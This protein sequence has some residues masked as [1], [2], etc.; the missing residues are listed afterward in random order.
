MEKKRTKRMVWVLAAFTLV[1]AL[2]IVTGCGD[3]VKNMEGKWYMVSVSGTSYSIEINPDGEFISMSGVGSWEETED[4]VIHTK[5]AFGTEQNFHLEDYH[6]YEILR[7]DETYF[8][9]Y[10]RTPEEAR[11]V[12][13]ISH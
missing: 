13:D 1:F 6:G 10:C 12:W 11:D 4:G 2:T 5:S 3:K 8:D 7:S 9:A